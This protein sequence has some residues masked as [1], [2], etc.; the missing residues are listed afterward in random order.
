MVSPI[1]EIP[2]SHSD[3]F[4]ENFQ[5]IFQSNWNSSLSLSLDHIP[6]WLQ[7][8]IFGCWMFHFMDIRSPL[9]LEFHEIYLLL[10]SIVDLF[11]SPSCIVSHKFIVNVLFAIDLDELMLHVNVNVTR[12]NRIHIIC[13]HICT[14]EWIRDWINS[15]VNT[16][17]AYVNSQHITLNLDVWID[18]EL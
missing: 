4:I 11:L 17:K 13:M 14:C 1:T 12:C 3:I 16:K 10:C 2:H 7:P 8:S 6:N 18:I 15:L 9:P 5:W